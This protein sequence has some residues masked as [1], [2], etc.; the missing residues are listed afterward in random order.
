MTVHRASLLRELI[1][2]LPKES[3]HPK[4]KLT[5]IIPNGSGVEIAFGDGMVYYFDVV[6]GAD[7]IF[8]TVREHVLRG[9]NADEHSSASP[10]GFWDCRNVVPFEKA[11]ATLGE[12]YFDVDRQYD[13][14]GDGAFILHDV[15]EDRTMVQCVI[16]GVEKDASKDR[17]RRRPLTRESLT[18]SLSSWLGGPIADGM[19]KVCASSSVLLIENCRSISSR[20]IDSFRSSSATNLI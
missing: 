15:L 20:K 3:L 2:P 11:K 1:A 13:W 9:V 8:S 16:S 17:D 14:V 12:K 10:A 4:K 6:I 19:I 7:G 5:A 18:S